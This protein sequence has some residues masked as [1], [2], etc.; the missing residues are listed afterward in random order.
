MFFSILPFLKRLAPAMPPGKLSQAAEHY[1]AICK[2]EV[3]MKS[4][5]KV[6]ET[7]LHIEGSISVIE[8]FSAFVG[9][10]DQLSGEQCF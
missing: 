10:F 1:S 8:I 3:L 2:S 5:I 9:P 7:T 4:N 6:Q